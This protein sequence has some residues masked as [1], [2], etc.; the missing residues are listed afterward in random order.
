MGKLVQFVIGFGVGAVAGYVTSRLLTPASS[1]D[2]QAG[3]RHRVETALEEGK[4]AGAA[5]E[6]ALKAQFAQEKHL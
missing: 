4:R 6:E 3:V 1:E 5:Q 2:L